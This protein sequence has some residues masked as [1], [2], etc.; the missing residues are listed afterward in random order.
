MIWIF[1]PPWPDAV[2]F[3]AGATEAQARAA[4]QR[5]L[6]PGLSADA[7][8]CAGIALGFQAP[9]DRPWNRA[10]ALVREAKDLA[11]PFRVRSGHE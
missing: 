2:C 11:Y 5:N 4:I 3:A 8:V 9:L 6:A 7:F 10:R 1:F